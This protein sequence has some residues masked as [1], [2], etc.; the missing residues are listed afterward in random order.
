MFLGLVIFAM[1]LLTYFGKVSGDALLF[2]VGIVVGYYEH[3]SR[4]TL[5]PMGD[6]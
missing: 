2:L 1:A 6:R 5:F 3:D 4:V